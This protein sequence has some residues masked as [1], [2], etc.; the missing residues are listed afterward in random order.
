MSDPMEDRRRYA[1]EAIAALQLEYE[2]AV[3]PYVDMLVAIES[4]NTR[5]IIISAK[6]WQGEIRPV[7]GHNLMPKD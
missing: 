1:M 4:M 3:K 6:Q 5:P 2:R 7:A